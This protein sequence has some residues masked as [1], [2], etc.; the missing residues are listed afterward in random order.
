MHER[1]ENLRHWASL[2]LLD[3]FAVVEQAMEERTI[4]ALAVAFNV[5]PKRLLR[6]FR[7]RLRAHAWEIRR[8]FEQALHDGDDPSDDDAPRP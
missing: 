2:A 6:A 5:N 1:L 3:P 4:V 7:H 8:E